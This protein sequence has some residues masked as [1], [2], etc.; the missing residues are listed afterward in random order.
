MISEYQALRTIALK[1]FGTSG[2]SANAI[3]S[4]PMDPASD[5]YRVIEVNARLSRS[6]ALASKAT[7]Y[8]LAYV[9][10]K[11]ALGYALTEVPNRVTGKTTA[12]FEPRLGLPGMH[13]LPRWDLTK[14]HGAVKQIG[15]EMKSVGEVMSIGRN[16]PEVLQKGLRMLDIGVHGLDPDHFEFDALDDELQRATPRRIFAIAKAIAN[17]RTTAE[18]A[19]LTRVDPWFI[20]A[21]RPVEA[22]ESVLECGGTGEPD[23]EQ[24]AAAKQLGFSDRAIEALTR[25][26]SGSIRDWRRRMGIGQTWAEIDTSAG[27]FPAVTNYLYSTYLATSSEI[28]PSLKPK[29]ML[30]GSGVYRIGSSVEFDWCCVNAVGAI[31]RMGYSTIMVNYNPETVS[32]N[33]DICDELIFDE[34]SIEG[35]LE[36]KK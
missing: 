23:A 12:F 21:L 11:L 20:D 19:Q 10:A 4:S 27:E 7:G 17:G 30:L 34:I 8:P 29:I 35:I 13:K 32:N 33:Y 18:I 2:S 3:F 16:F 1:K 28:A 25:L 26:P 36:L 5:E 9:A 6:S 15:S 22:M 14:F 24:L 31:S